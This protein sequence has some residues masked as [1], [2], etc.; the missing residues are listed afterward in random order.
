MYSP[1]EAEEDT[2]A[3]NLAILFFAV[4]AIAVTLYLHHDGALKYWLLENFGERTT[5]TVLSLE[6]A[7]DNALDLQARMRENPRNYLKNSRSWIHGQRLHI[8]YKPDG[9]IPLLLTMTLPDDMVGK[10]VTETLPV[11]FLPI[12]PRIAYPTDYLSD[13]ALDS[14]IVLW[15]LAIGAFLL[16]FSYDAILAWLGFRRNMQRY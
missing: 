15:A 4:L 16:I 6:H 11:S 13:F 14:K 7:P 3:L 5:G 1:K 8:E 12:N 9:P 10:P 2:H